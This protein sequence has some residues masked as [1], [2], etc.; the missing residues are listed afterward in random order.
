[1]VSGDTYE[2]STFD[3]A[4]QNAYIRC[5]NRYIRGM[6]NFSTT[7]QDS[8]TSAF[9]YVRVYNYTHL[10]ILEKVETSFLGFFIIR[11]TGIYTLFRIFVKVGRCTGI[12]IDIYTRTP[13]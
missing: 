6:Y 8:Q 13:L 11:R 1:M 4:A 2:C 5:L 9:I 12:Y 3:C 10:K 7:T